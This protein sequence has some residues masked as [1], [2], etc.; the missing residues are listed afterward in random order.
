MFSTLLLVRTYVRSPPYLSQ[1]GASGHFFLHV[2]TP[3]ME[4]CLLHPME[5]AISRA[6]LN[7]IYF[8]SIFFSIISAFFFVNPRGNEERSSSFFVFWFGIH[9]SCCMTHISFFFQFRGFLHDLIRSRNPKKDKNVISFQNFQSLK[10]LIA[11]STVRFV[12]FFSVLPIW[13]H[14]SLEALTAP[15]AGPP[16]LA[17][18]ESIAA[19]RFAGGGTFLRYTNWFFYLS[20]R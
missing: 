1:S 13:E 9:L 3:S 11:E 4:S 20:Q 14:L 10:K 7:F 19:S 18:P 16:L 15:S 5:I 6:K 12:G 17:G 2:H 8:R